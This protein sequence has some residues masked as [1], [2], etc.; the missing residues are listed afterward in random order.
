MGTCTQC[1]T[2]CCTREGSHNT[3]SPRG[4]S[5]GHTTNCNKK[6]LSKS[7]SNRYKVIK[8]DA[9][10]K[11]ISQSTS[12]K[13]SDNP[14]LDKSSS[15]SR[16]QCTVI[17][18]LK[19]SHSTFTLPDINDEDSIKIELDFQHYLSEHA[20]SDDP[21]MNKCEDEECQ[22]D[23]SPPYFMS[24]HQRIHAYFYHS[25]KCRKLK[26]Q[27]SHKFLQNTDDPDNVIDDTNVTT[28]H[29]HIGDLEDGLESLDSDDFHTDIDDEEQTEQ[30][31]LTINVAMS[32]H[33]K[34][35]R[36]T[37]TPIT[38]KKHLNLGGHPSEIS[39]DTSQNEGTYNLSSQI[40]RLLIPALNQE[41]TR[42]EGELK[43]DGSTS[44]PP[45]I[46]PKQVHFNPSI[47]RAPS[48]SHMYFGQRQELCEESTNC[49]KIQ[50]LL[51]FCENINP[52]E[53]TKEEYNE[54]TMK[55]YWDHY[56]ES[57]LEEY[58]KLDCIH[59]NEPNIDQKDEDKD[60]DEDED[61]ECKYLMLV[62][63]S[64]N[65]KS[66]DNTESNLQIALHRHFYHEN[67][68]KE[69]N[70]RIKYVKE[71]MHGQQIIDKFKPTINAILTGSGNKINQNK[72]LEFGFPFECDRS[73]AKF[74]NPKEEILQNTICP[75]DVKHWN[76]LFNKCS[77]SNGY[78]KALKTRQMKLKLK[79]VI[80]LKLYTG[81]S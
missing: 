11:H 57:H 54:E 32:D 2:G 17:Q 31:N 37:I 9:M 22:F 55:S 12:P 70:D 34:E 61:T 5:H 39:Q 59:G 24:N 63:S 51:K 41:F 72:V 15:C 10:E 65:L 80:V 26:T 78:S 7:N 44:P 69:E 81:K 42:D 74:K 14:D 29:S 58:Q 66:T 60:D 18:D 68:M 1:V 8:S 20:Q 6:D 53:S 75:I 40:S 77:V 67:I 48:I 71:T 46:N 30:T 49:H 38:T 45:P 19:E 79:E 23:T 52:D 56:C 13:P 50:Q 76:Q 43:R 4:I 35:H 73:E 27:R 3:D 21:S 28:L 62:N 47:S 25:E 36:D 33:T 16:S 64:T